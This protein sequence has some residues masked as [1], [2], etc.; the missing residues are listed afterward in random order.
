MINLT[1]L[2]FEKI[3]EDL[4]NYLQSRPDYERWKDFF[5]SSTGTILIELLA[6]LGSFLSHLLTVGRREA[7]LFPAML[8]SSTIAMAQFLGYSA[9]RGKN[10]TATLTITPEYTTSV[11]RFSSI[12]TYNDY[13]L[14]ILSDVFL[15]EGQSQNVEVVI[16]KKGEETLSIDTNG[17][18]RFSTAFL[19]EDVRL[20]LD[21]AEVE[22]GT[23]FEDLLNDKWLL[24]TNPL[25][26]VDAVYLGEITGTH[27]LTLEYILFAQVDSID[28]SK[29]QCYYGTIESLVDFT[30]YQSPESI[31]KIKSVAPAYHDLQKVIRSRE[32]YV[33]LV[34]QLLPNAVDV[35]GNDPSPPEVQ[36][37]YVLEDESLLSDDDKTSLLNEL[38]KYRPFGLPVPTIVDPK[39]LN[40]EIIAQLKVYSGSNMDEIKSTVQSVAGSFSKKLGITVDVDE[41]ES[42]I[43]SD[44]AVK[45]A[46]VQWKVL[47]EF[48]GAGSTATSTF[49]VRFPPVVSGSDMVYIDGTPAKEITSSVTGE[50]VGT[51]S[52]A[53]TTV[54]T[55]T[56]ANTNIKPSTVTVHYT[57][58][59]TNYTAADDGNGNITGTYLTG[60]INY[61]TGD[62]SLTFSSAPD[63][64]TNITVDY[65]YFP[66]WYTMNYT[67]GEITFKSPPPAGSSITADYITTLNEAQLEWNEY[68]TMSY[69]I[70]VEVV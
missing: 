56:L 2:S 60:T 3:K 19:S 63:A 16:G 68:T 33:K 34:K 43:E 49:T 14:V 5:E 8:K 7:Y 61:T 25:E 57:I 64:G 65:L 12:G 27:E 36:I 46:R 1:S 18:H 4:L 67:T 39:K 13:D 35:A 47:G 62:I 24:V 66:Y 32:D 40:S 23:S 28:I 30:R 70:S 45:V 52:T 22:L 48:L 15:T 26:S 59:T 51:G 44:S 20:L 58:G 6:G 38:D 10:S 37:S 17:I 41:I 9:F 50:V 21:G 69:Q 42:M 29:A 54:F 53:G 11:A 55:A 31:D